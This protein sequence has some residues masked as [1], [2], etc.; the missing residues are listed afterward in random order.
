MEIAISNLV[1]LLRRDPFQLRGGVKYCEADG[2]MAVTKPRR[3]IFT[4]K[5]TK[6]FVAIASANDARRP[7]APINRLTCRNACYAR[8][9]EDIADS[10][11]VLDNLD[12]SSI[13][14]FQVLTEML[15]SSMYRYEAAG[16]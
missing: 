7:Y 16:F 15:R 11:V 9:L 6:V 8:W 5:T 10:V 3:F 13:V 14:L 12:A 1:V 2:L 4:M